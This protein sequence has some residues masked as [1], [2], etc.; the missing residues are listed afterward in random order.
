VPAAAA[1]TPGVPAAAACTPAAATTAPAG[2][3]AAP[4][5]RAAVL[6][7]LGALAAAL[8]PARA[9]AAEDEITTDRPDVVESAEVVPNVQI[10]TGINDARSRHDGAQARTL[11]TPTLLRIALSRAFELRLE[12]DG[13][14][15]ASV[16]DA[17]GAHQHDQG[18]A[19]TALELKWHFQEDDGSGRASMAWLA[20]VEMPTGAAAFRG[21]GWRPSLRLVSEWALQDEFSLGVMPG[22]TLDRTAAGQEFANGL[23]AVVLDNGFAPHWDAFV[24]L[25]AQQIA[26]RRYGGNVLTFD[27]GIAH[28]LTPDFQVDAALYVGLTDAAPAFQWGVGASY[29]F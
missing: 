27:T 18:M 26:A 11:T 3:P 12:T 13:Y 1:C 23:F 25:A 7:L 14:A 21:R 4:T 29:R 24:E 6:A 17:A 15:D 5:A 19:D 2:M 9:C 10:E 8:C 28:R 20:G 22:I 16:T